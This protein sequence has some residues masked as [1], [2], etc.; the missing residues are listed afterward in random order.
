MFSHP[1]TEQWKYQIAGLGCSLGLA[2]GGGALFGVISKYLLGNFMSLDPK[3]PF[4]DFEF[5]ETDNKHGKEKW[6][7]ELEVLTPRE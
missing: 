5:F 6:E 3:H 1:I 4:E 2:I 7:S